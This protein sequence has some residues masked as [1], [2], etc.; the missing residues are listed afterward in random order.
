MN[1]VTLAHWGDCRAKNKQK[2]SCNTIFVIFFKTPM[3]NL[4]EEF[5]N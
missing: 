4:S 1:E 2:N 3:C 5:D